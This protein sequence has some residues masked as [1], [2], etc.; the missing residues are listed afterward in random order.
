MMEMRTN[1]FRA[2]SQTSRWNFAISSQF[3]LT[4][5][6]LGSFANAGIALGI[7]SF[8][9]LAHDFQ[10]DERTYHLNVLLHSSI[11]NPSRILTISEVLSL[12][13]VARGFPFF[14]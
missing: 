8:R 13:E 4:I 5:S 6:C 11:S 2:T 3:C 7:L 12:S 9:L 10:V 14:F 1:S